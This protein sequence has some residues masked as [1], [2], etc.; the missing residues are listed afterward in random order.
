MKI[1]YR[2]SKDENDLEIKI[3]GGR[4]WEFC[5]RLDK[6][7]KLFP[8]V[9][10]LTLNYCSE[11]IPYLWDPTVK[12]GEADVIDCLKRISQDINIKIIIGDLRIEENCMLRE[13]P[14]NITFES[15]NYFENY[16]YQMFIKRLENSS[17]Q[18]KVRDFNKQCSK[19]YTSIS[20]QLRGH[21]LYFLQELEKLNLLDCGY[22][23]C[24]GRLHQ[25]SYFDRIKGK[26]KKPHTYRHYFPA[27]YNLEELSDKYSLLFGHENDIKINDIGHQKEL[28]TPQNWIRDSYIWITNE[29]IFSNGGKYN[30][31]FITEKTYK[32]IFNCV[33]FL[34][35]GGA[36]TLAQLREDGFETFPELFDESYDQVESSIKRMG[37]VVKEMQ[38]FC[39]L[40]KKDIH[41]KIWLMQDKLLHNRNCI[42]ERGRV[43]DQIKDRSDHIFW[44]ESFEI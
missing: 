23:S 25:F 12:I 6:L 30:E 15:V 27:D 4:V 33:P 42:I 1:R 26:K 22:I 17:E 36:G 14:S 39:S 10:N 11:V 9:N 43:R 18:Y 41:K 8:A 13:I 32:P 28:N 34:M 40:D 37:L 44:N 24:L 2:L 35:I 38:K 20:G 31:L 29:T 3:P 7:L 19:I 16:Y 5:N 21:R